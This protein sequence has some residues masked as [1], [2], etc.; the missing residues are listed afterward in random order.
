VLD[1]IYGI[2]PRDNYTLAQ[3]GKVPDRGYAQFLSNKSALKG[4]VFGLPWESFWVHAEDE[5]QEKLLA[6]IAL[7]EDAGATIINGTELPNYQTIVSPDGWNW[8]VQLGG[9]LLRSEGLTEPGTMA[10]PE[11]L[12][13][14]A[15]IPL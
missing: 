9:V 8:Y 3:E 7:I 15:S 11:A 4:A 1:G 13:M 12:R 10:Q 2:D 6:L 5:M 14:K